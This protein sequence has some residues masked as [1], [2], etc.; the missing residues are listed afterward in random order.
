[1]MFLSGKG[2]LL[3]SLM[4]CSLSS[5]ADLRS[6]P[7]DDL[8]QYSGQAVFAIDEYQV[9]QSDA[10]NVDFMR[11]TYGAEIDVN[12]TVDK[13]ELGK[14]DR[15]GYTAEADIDI[16]DFSLGHID[17]VTKEYVPFAVTDPY[18]EFAF[19]NDSGV[20]DIIG[21]RI[22]FGSAEGSLTADI[23]VLT[24]NVGVKLDD[25]SGAVSE[26]QLL[27]MTGSATQVRA[28]HI[29]LEGD[30]SANCA[31][32]SDVSTLQIGELDPTNGAQA[33]QDMFLSYQN[34]DLDWAKSVNNPSQTVNTLQGAYINLPTS[35]S[36]TTGVLT[37]PARVQATRYTDAS[38]GLF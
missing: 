2:C 16:D 36:V 20:R 27:D 11:L 17:P 22:G 12:L 5:Y 19:S 8:S 7:D 1:M 35:M 34:I 38:L 10:S 33:S 14:Y 37:D 28:T 9:V 21:F 6:I 18:I 25:G 30:C 26:A 29:G 24:G 13:V 32:L 4:M 3:F 23:N 31:E 15:A